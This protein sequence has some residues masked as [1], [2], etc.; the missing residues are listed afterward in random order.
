V[1]GR[2]KIE[3]RPAV[4]KALKDLDRPAHRRIQAAIELL[5]GNPVHLVPARYK[6]GRG[7]GSG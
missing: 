1:T 6:A 3:L 4:R 7:R 5:A 2:Y